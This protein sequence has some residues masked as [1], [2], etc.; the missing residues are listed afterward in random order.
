MKLGMR[1]LFVLAAG[2]YMIA[3]SA[4]STTEKA[5]EQAAA[6]EAPAIAPELAPA[7]VVTQ[8]PSIAQNDSSSTKGLWGASSTGRSH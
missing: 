3:A 1:S 6:V 5:P 4:C 2:I 8:A 7:P